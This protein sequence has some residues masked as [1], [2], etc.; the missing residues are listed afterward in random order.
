M[1]RDPAGLATASGCAIQWDHALLPDRF[2]RR[3]PDARNRG[4]RE[5]VIAAKR[6]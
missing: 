5:R 3:K 1:L 6:R 2:E 4:H